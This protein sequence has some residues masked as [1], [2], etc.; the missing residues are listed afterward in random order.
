MGIAGMKS[1]KQ[2]IRVLKEYNDYIDK[3]KALYNY[4]DLAQRILDQTDLVDVDD[5]NDFLRQCGPPIKKKGVFTATYFKLNRLPL[6]K[7]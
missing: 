4:E 1:K 5:Y 3:E 7:E 2:L 6:L